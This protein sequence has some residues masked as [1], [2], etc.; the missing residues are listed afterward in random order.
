M[1]H[2]NSSDVIIASLTQYGR[3]VAN[4]RISGLSDLGQVIEYIKKAIHGIIGMTSL[5]LR[6]GSQGWVEELHLMFGTSPADSRRPQ[7]LSLF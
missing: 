2:I 6:N 3:N 4:L 1:K 7:Q 5:R